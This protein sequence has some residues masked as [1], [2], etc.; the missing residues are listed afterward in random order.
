MSTQR[1]EINIALVSDAENLDDAKDVI[2]H[3]AQKKGH[4]V[5]ATSPYVLRNFNFNNAVINIIEIPTDESQVDTFLNTHS[6]KSFDATISAILDKKTTLIFS[7]KTIDQLNIKLGRKGGLS[8]T[9][10][11]SQQATETSTRTTENDGAIEGILTEIIEGS[12]ATSSAT[13]SSKGSPKSHPDKTKETSYKKSK[14]S[15]IVFII[16]LIVSIALF[17]ALTLAGLLLTPSI[18]VP[19][20]FLL[21]AITAGI[22]VYLD[23]RLSQSAVTT[24]VADN[25]DGTWEDRVDMEET[26]PQKASKFANLLVYRKNNID[27]LIV[28]VGEIVRYNPTTKTLTEITEST[29]GS[30]S[31]KFVNKKI[32]RISF[33][34]QAERNPSG[35]LLIAY[36]QTSKEYFFLNIPFVKAQDDPNICQRFFQTFSGVNQDAKFD[37]LFFGVAP[38]K[39][40]GTNI[41]FDP[42]PNQIMPEKNIASFTN[43]KELIDQ[44][45]TPLRTTLQRINKE[46]GNQVTEIGVTYM[47]GRGSA[48]QVSFTLRDRQ[49]T[50]FSGLHKTP[51]REQYLVWEIEK[52]QEQQPTTNPSLEKKS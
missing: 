23:N 27:T 15:L 28:N 51:S 4:S 34:C 8:K 5:N 11:L 40:D 47:R 19:F 13:S 36:N 24:Q 6:I 52:N 42:L 2:Y 48:T 31:H 46:E 14:R 16:T 43:E 3:F 26:S 7:N 29:T 39:F 33:K 22:K 25:P 18:I 32:D 9:L 44:E 17:I 12:T 21:V 35:Y 45:K 10:I 30:Y 38:I 50:K 37:V 41:T 49:L 20:I 1:T